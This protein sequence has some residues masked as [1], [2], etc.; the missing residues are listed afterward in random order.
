[1]SGDSTSGTLGR[2]RLI[3]FVSRLSFLF[4]CLATI[5]SGHSVLLV[6]SGDRGD[7]V[8][9]S[10]FSYCF[11]IYSLGSILMTFIFFIKFYYNGGVFFCYLEL[12]FFPEWV[13]YL[14]LTSL[15]YFFP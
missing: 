4:L 11:L 12:L 1:M 8:T 7:L 6:V 3:P 15:S 2:L 5:V 10:S 9:F 13:L 14:V